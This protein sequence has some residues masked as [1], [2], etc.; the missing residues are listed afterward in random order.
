MYMYNPCVYV[1][2]PGMHVYNPGM[3]V[4]NPRV[5]VYKP[6]VHTYTYIRK[7]KL[8]SIPGRLTPLCAVIVTFARLQ[9]ILVQAEAMARL[10]PLQSYL[11][12]FCVTSKNSRSSSCSS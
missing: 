3:H 2:S 8:R 4:Y 11:M 12:L 6:C 5:H 7:D 1:Y 10:L 9:R